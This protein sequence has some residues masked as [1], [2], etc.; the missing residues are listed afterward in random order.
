[1]SFHP[2]DELCASGA[3]VRP[4]LMCG[5]A[6]GAGVARAIGGVGDRRRVAGAN[7]PLAGV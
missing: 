3:L 2:S 7:R 4:G 6:E 1:M 5:G